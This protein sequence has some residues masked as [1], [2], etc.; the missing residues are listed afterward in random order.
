MVATHLPAR[1]R[2]PFSATLL[3][4]TDAKVRTL[5]RDY[6]GKDKATNVLSFP[7]FDAADLPKIGKQRPPVE[8]GDIAIAYQTV[9]KEAKDSNKLMKDHVT[10]LTIHGLLHLFGYDHMVDD[11]ADKMEKLETR[12]MKALGLPDPYAPLPLVAE[13]PARTTKRPRP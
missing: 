1:L 7:Q 5:N 8:V 3:L 9:A 4:T 2:F 6:R 13:K 10:H 12:I 11:D